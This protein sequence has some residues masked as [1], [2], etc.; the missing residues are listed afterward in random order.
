MNVDAKSYVDFKKKIATS[1]NEI[2]AIYQHQVEKL[3][4]S[5]AS[6]IKSLEAYE[7]DG[8]SKWETFKHQ[9]GKDFE[10]FEKEIAG[11]IKNFG[12]HNK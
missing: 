9:F 12:N 10:E 6:L 2:A 7:E 8:E 4:A 5:K 3:E 11:F 1:D